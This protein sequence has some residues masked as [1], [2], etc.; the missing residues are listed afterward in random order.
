MVFKFD[1]SIEEYLTQDN[2]ETPHRIYVPPGNY[3]P[4]CIVNGSNPLADVKIMNGN[5]KMPGE[6]T[7]DLT[8]SPSTQYVAEAAEFKG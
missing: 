3:S 5:L 1:S 7:V 2:N 6:R 8:G 4:F